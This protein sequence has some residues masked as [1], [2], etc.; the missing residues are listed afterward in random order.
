MSN[1]STVTVAKGI[2]CTDWLRAEF[3][4]FLELAVVA[5]NC[6]DWLGSNQVLCLDLD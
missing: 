2:L 3:L 5:R 4:L 6:N 1:S